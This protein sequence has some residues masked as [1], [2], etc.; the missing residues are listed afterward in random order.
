MEKFTSPDKAKSSQPD[1]PNQERPGLWERHDFQVNG[2]QV[3]F[4]GVSHELATLMNPVFRKQLEGAVKRSSVVILESAPIVDNEDLKKNFKLELS[5]SEPDGYNYSMNSGG[6]YDTAN[7]YD[8]KRTSKKEAPPNF[9]AADSATDSSHL[10]FL[11]VGKMARE[12]S[13]PIVV[14]DPRRDYGTG[15]P[16][17]MEKLDAGIQGMKAGSAVFLGGL[18]A[19]ELLGKKKKSNQEKKDDSPKS[20]SEQ[21]TS[22]T[23]RN[24]LR[25]LLGAGAM[26]GAASSA[27]EGFQKHFESIGR[28][29]NPLGTVLYDELDFRDVSVAKGLIELTKEKNLPD[30]PMV[31]IYGSAHEN[32]VQHY[33]ESPKER[34]AK[35]LAYLPHRKIAPPTLS[36]YEFNDESGWEEKIRKE[37]K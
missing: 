1:L 24:F 30:G 33:L 4:H 37:I 8:E 3:E 32:G 13:K 11:L 35:F 19:H 29:K 14:I 31:M 2:K 5:S 18:A 7:R 25:G 22:I 20:N 28:K 34:E 12:Y 16:A 15:K 23:R 26:L 36:L 27:A 17:N 6:G 21:N 9:E 10:F